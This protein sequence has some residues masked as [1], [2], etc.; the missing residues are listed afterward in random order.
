MTKKLPN[1]KNIGRKRSLSRLMA[2]QI[3]YQ[4]DFLRDAKKL[5]E[6]KRDI[7]ENYLIDEKENISS[8][9]EKIDE[10]FLDN[11]LAGL[12]LDVKKID[13]EISTVLKTGWSIDN[14]D[15]VVVQ[16]LRFG[17]FELKFM[18]DIPTKV[19]LDEYVDIAASFF[20]GKK[21]MFVN[22]ALDSLA[23]KLRENKI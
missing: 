14:L 1:K 16:I 19:I 6:V 22:A 18:Q 10:S 3:F 4:F 9:R 8:Y 2:I 15:S 13:E 17:S 20:E 21:V 11:L 7:I 12:S 5:D 23:K